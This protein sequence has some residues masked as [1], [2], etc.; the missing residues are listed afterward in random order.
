MQLSLIN[1]TGSMPTRCHQGMRLR[2]M[3]VHYYAG[4]ERMVSGSRCYRL[5]TAETMCLGFAYD[6]PGYPA[7]HSAEGFANRSHVCVTEVSG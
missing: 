4:V 3:A 1:V 2:K 5:C 7:N 6:T